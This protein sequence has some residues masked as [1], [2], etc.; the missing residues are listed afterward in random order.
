MSPRTRPEL[1]VRVH[2]S[3]FIID[4]SLLTLLTGCGV[5]SVTRVI[6]TPVRT[7][8]EVRT[9]DAKSRVLATDQQSLIVGQ[10]EFYEECVKVT[11]HENSRTQVSRRSGTGLLIA[12]LSIG[13]AVTGLGAY[14]LASAPNR[15]ARPGIDDEGERT[16]SPRTKSYVW[17]TLLTAGGVVA[18]GHGTATAIQTRAREQPLTNVVHEDAS[19]MSECNA[20]PLTG[21]TLLVTG[22]AMGL[23]AVSAGVTLEEDGSFAFDLTS[24]P[25]FEYPASDGG[26]TSISIAVVSGEEAEISTDVDIGSWIE[27]P[28]QDHRACPSIGDCA[29]LLAK[30]ESKPDP[31]LRQIPS[32]VRSRLLE[33]AA[34][35]EASC[36]EFRRR[37]ATDA[38]FGDTSAIRDLCDFFVA[39]RKNN[40]RALQG[41]LAKPRAA[42]LERATERLAFRL[43]EKNPREADLKWFIGKFPGSVNRDDAEDLLLE[44][45]YAGV[46]ASLL[47]CCSDTLSIKQI[48]DNEKKGWSASLAAAHVLQSGA[49][50][51]ALTDGEIETLRK[52]GMRDEV[53]QAII[54]LAGRAK[55]E[56]QARAEERER[57]S[58]D[59]RQCIQ[60]CKQVFS[61]CGDRRGRDILDAMIFDQTG[62]EQEAQECVSTCR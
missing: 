28:A 32:V 5:S 29:A 48:L 20:R 23:D 9:I 19:P 59:Q 27:K 52:A 1:E 42:H 31:K 55:A 6:E 8:E 34:E 45:E 61:E 10:A 36:H 11:H 24:L 44:L 57:A 17:G 43:I 18:L 58:R 54:T 2:R 49:F 21:R 16:A 50:F 46:P 51:R 13:A 40:M 33:L 25:G 38:S 60:R 35:S 41:F 12:E 37:F 47:R 53:I 62:C 56:E 7:W 3:S 4:C 14:L 15:S 22:R 26:D 30:L 39:K